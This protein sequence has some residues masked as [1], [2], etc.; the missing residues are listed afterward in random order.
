MKN[1]KDAIFWLKSG[2]INFQNLKLG[3]FQRAPLFFQK[4]FSS[5]ITS[6]YSAY[7]IKKLDWDT[8]NF[9]HNSILKAKKHGKLLREVTHTNK[10]AN[11]GEILMCISHSI[12]HIL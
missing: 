6:F 11:F 1:I 2:Q 3:F 9:G 10:G 12:K 4:F 7:N 5:K 8:G